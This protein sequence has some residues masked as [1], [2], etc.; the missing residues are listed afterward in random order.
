MWIDRR[1]RF[2][3]VSAS[4]L[5]NVFLIGIVAGHVWAGR[6][7]AHPHRGDLPV[8][9]LAN[10]RKLQADQRKLFQSTFES[11]RS[12]IRAARI[13]QHRLKLIAE[14]DIASA[15]FD[16]SKVTADLAALRDANMAVQVAANT[17]L[18]DS[19]GKLSQE[20]RSILVNDEFRDPPGAGK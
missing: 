4:L 5:L 18:V 9:P 6:A 16:Q 11:H 7:P 1:W 15:D 19:L 20:A 2:V 12:T 17:A 8:V 14:A 3:S 10:Q 13:E